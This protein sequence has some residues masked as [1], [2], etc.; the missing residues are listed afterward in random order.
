VPATTVLA[1]ITGSRVTSELQNCHPTEHTQV[2]GKGQEHITSHKSWLASF[3]K[4]MFSFSNSVNSWNHTT[5]TNV[6]N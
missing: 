5:G 6:Q 3:N 1:A 4:Q 2:S